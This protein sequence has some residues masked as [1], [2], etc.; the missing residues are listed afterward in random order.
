MQAIASRLSPPE[1]LIPRVVE[2]PPS[3]LQKGRADALDCLIRQGNAV[4]YLTIS[5]VIDHLPADVSSDEEVDDFL[6]LLGHEEFDLIHDERVA[7]RR[8]CIRCKK[9]RSPHAFSLE[10]TYRKTRRRKSRTVT[11]QIDH[12]HTCRKDLQLCPACQ[13]SSPVIEFYGCRSNGCAPSRYCKKCRARARRAEKKYDVPINRFLKTLESQGGVCAICTRGPAADLVVD[14]CH[15][16]EKF[17]GLLCRKCNVGLGLFDDEPDFLR[18][19]IEYLERYY[20]PIKP[21]CSQ[22]PG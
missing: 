18:K 14:H 19:G 4:G 7:E 3:H 21:H 5:Q 13:E 1:P 6:K 9:S 16:R 10:C 20:P 8:V 17:R 22:D 15:A 11:F 2:A 12:C